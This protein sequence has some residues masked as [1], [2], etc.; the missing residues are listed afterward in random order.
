[1]KFF[2]YGNI[3]YFCIY[4]AVVIAC[5]AMSQKIKS[6]NWAGLGAIFV[7]ALFLMVNATVIDFMLLYHTPTMWI[8]IL[9]DIACAIFIPYLYFYLC[10]ML[11][12]KN[13]YWNI[14]LM[15]SFSLLLLLPNIIISLDGTD[16]R[17][18]TE[19]P[20][21]IINSRF[22]SIVKGGE[23]LLEMPLYFLVVLLHIIVCALPIIAEFERAKA[24]RLTMNRPLRISLI[25]WCSFFLLLAICA[26]LPMSFV[27]TPIGRWIV[28]L[29]YTLPM[30]AVFI[31]YGMGNDEARFVEDD[32]Q[33][34]VG[35]SDTFSEFSHLA[36]AARLLF[37]DDSF[38]FQ[39]G[40]LVD[41]AVARLGTNRTYFTRMMKAEF[42]CNFNEYLA[43]VRTDKARILLK[44]TN[45]PL[46]EIA[47]LCGFGDS[48]SLN[49][50]F[51]KEVGETPDRWRRAQR[52]V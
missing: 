27:T 30:C 26:P 23:M 34:K 36:Q 51:K 37:K 24:L 25:I 41:E 15:S 7:S 11:G 17:A 14:V 13:F 9:N 52:G 5:W 8:L 43:K 20:A 1:M 45:K 40:L 31:F 47:T 29:A 35:L 46:D 2:S 44:E 10:K 39:Q 38:V 42:G 12:L 33:K 50:T 16:V 3:A 6:R 32:T 49:R 19:L 48:S 4:I 22:I 18:A 21:T 28:F